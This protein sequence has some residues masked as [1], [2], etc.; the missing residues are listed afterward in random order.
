MDQNKMKASLLNRIHAYRETQL[1]YVAARLGISDL[2]WDGE[3]SI[4]ELAV[5]TRT[6]K[7]SLYRMLRACTCLGLYE[8]QDGKFS[9]TDMGK[10]VASKHPDS[11]RSAAIM[12][13]EEVN[14]KPWGELLYAVQT[15][16]SAFEKVFEMNLFEYY[17]K[18][19]ESGRT[20]NDGM[21]VFTK[22]DIELILEN[23]NF[24]GFTKIIDIGGGNGALL[25]AIVEKHRACRGIVYDLVHVAREAEQYI[26]RSKVKANI[27]VIPGDIFEDV[28]GGG[29]CY[30]LKK[31]LHDW[32]DERAVRILKNCRKSI[33]ET[34]RLL[35]M[36]YV[37]NE[38]DRQGKIND[39]HMMVVCPGGKERTKEE[40]RTLL[41]QSGFQIL[42]IIDTAFLS[43][44]ECAVS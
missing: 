4:D 17:E 20:F 5:S 1:I 32:D 9:L 36:E 18:N 3:K 42:R 12:R 26:D 27:T 8:E 34:G 25:I 13:G 2:L 22:V 10:L 21:R 19:S 39:V 41:K 40:F 28:P 43:I 24:G 38:N 35:I 16:E 11:I 37:I 44:I 31:I 14:W 33:K 30:I 7:E 23:Y 29:D 15:G 6:H